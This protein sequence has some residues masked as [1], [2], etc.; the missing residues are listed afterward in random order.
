MS[1]AKPKDSKVFDVAKPG[2]TAADASS[3]PV[4]V[5]NRPVM[6]DPM[7]ADE[8][9]ESEAVAGE[10]PQS[11]ND[12][13]APSSTHLKLEPLSHDDATPKEETTKVTDEAPSPT[14]QSQNDTESQTADDEASELTKPK[15]SVEEQELAARKEA[16]QVEAV[17]ALAAS[18]KYYL[19]INQVEKR[20]NKQYAVAGVILIIILGLM[21][22]DI[23]LDAGIVSIPGV[24]APTHFFK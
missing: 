16:E 23:A 21:W 13:T 10:T 11:A 4:I 19:P 22:A 1:D 7:V 15:L 12:S 8:K 20:R 14:R 6:K 9:P 24:K 5:T 17:D 3:R 2:K 18:R